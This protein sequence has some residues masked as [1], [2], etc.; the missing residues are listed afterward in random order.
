MS[1]RGNN[2]EPT[3]QQVLGSISDQSNID[4]YNPEN[5]RILEQYVDAQAKED[6]YNLEANL[7]LLKL[8]QLNPGG[9]YAAPRASYVTKILLKALMQLPRSDFQ[10]CK[11]LT[12][13][14]LERV[15][16]IRDVMRLDT[17]LETCQ[18]EFFWGDLGGSRDSVAGVEGFDTAIRNYIC[19]I[20]GMTNQN[21]NERQLNAFLGKLPQDKFRRFVEEKGWKFL[22]NNLVYIKDQAASIKSRKITEAIEFADVAPILSAAARR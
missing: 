17:L 6:F 16:R 15:L 11:A 7:T 2:P 8:Y 5:I 1:A 4:R 22:G 3:L 18:F 14:E 10:I 19:S 21:I 12:D 20:I 9:S 13:P